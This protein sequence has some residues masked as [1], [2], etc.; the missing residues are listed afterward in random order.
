MLKKYSEIWDKIES[1][2]KKEFDKK[3][4]YKNKYNSSKVYNNM[5]HIEFTF[6]KVLEDNKHCKYISIEPKSGDCHAYLS[7][8]Y[9]ILFLLIQRN[10]IHNY[11]LKTA[12]MR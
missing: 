5:M 4:L 12:C 8:N 3:P 9:Y 11:F 10:I 2:S 7:T 1:L 6:K